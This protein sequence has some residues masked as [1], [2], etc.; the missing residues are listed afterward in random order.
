M[1]YPRKISAL[2][3]G[4]ETAPDRAMQPSFPLDSSFTSS[5]PRLGYLD[6]SVANEVFKQ[7]VN[8]VLASVSGGAQKLLYWL[9]TG[10]P[11]P[12]TQPLGLPRR[13]LLMGFKLPQQ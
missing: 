12:S 4:T 3:F 10:W 5:N 8:G 7:S 1:S 9:C 6:L 11:Q 2:S 13:K